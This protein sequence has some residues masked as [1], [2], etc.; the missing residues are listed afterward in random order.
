[1]NTGTNYFELSKAKNYQK[2][3]DDLLPVASGDGSI[4]GAN[5]SYLL[6][7][8]NKMK[9]YDDAVSIG[10]KHFA[11]VKN[12]KYALNSLCFGVYMSRIN[13]HLSDEEVSAETA[14]TAGWIIDNF[15]K[16]AKN[17]IWVNSL[18]RAVEYM[19]VHNDLPKAAALLSR[20]NPAELSDEVKEIVKDGKTIRLKSDRTKFLRFSFDLAK[21][22]GDNSEALRICE[23]MLEKDPTD[24]WN[25]RRKAQALEALGKNEESMTIYRQVLQR[26]TDWYIWHEAAKLALKMGQDE[27]AKVYFSRAFNAA[28]SQTA[29][30]IW[31]LLVDIAL[32]LEKHGNGDLSKKHLEY[33]L[34]AATDDNGNKPQEMLKFFFDRKTKPAENIDLKALLKE[35]K[36]YHSENEFTGE[37]LSGTISRMNEGGKSGF[38][39]SDG[40]SYFFLAR[41]FRGK[42]PKEG[43]AVTFHLEKHTNPKTGNEEDQAVGIAISD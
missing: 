3:I 4:S 39:S 40:K 14:K 41:N 27:D 11:E 8:L 1:M 24:I 32:F 30:F 34:H 38:I 33:V 23:L 10:K 2:I 17:F 31:H 25:L 43:I 42:N 36:A 26:K 20:T 9:R 21:S 18:F 19:L 13:P 35:L 22:N 37:K 7:A 6:D 15:P 28:G 16:D 12:N 29:I 5:L